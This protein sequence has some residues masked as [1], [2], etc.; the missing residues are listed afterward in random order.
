MLFCVVTWLQLDL[1]FGTSQAIDWKNQGFFHQLSDWLGR[2]IITGMTCD[3]LSVTL[4]PTIT[5]S[6]VV[7]QCYR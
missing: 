2:S 6:T 7:L 4:N 3:V 5:C 1:V